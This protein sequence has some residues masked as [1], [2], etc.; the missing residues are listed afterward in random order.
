MSEGTAVQESW[1]GGEGGEG[2]RVLGEHPLSATLSPLS[3][4]GA[5]HYG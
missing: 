4:H 1:V 3:S 2:W 5:L